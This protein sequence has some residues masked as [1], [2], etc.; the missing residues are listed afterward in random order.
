MPELPLFFPIYGTLVVFYL[1]LNHY[2][3]CGFIISSLEHL[4]AKC[5][6]MTSAWHNTHHNRGRRGWH[7]TDQTFAEMLT[8]WDIWLG[9]YP[10]AAKT[11]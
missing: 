7:A 10:E 8:I 6:F 2:L 3:H 9:T 1:V 4:L 5:Y 11:H